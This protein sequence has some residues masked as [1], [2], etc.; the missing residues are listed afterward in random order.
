MESQLGWLEG[1]GQGGYGDL[2]TRLS[3]FSWR[4]GVCC[5]AAP[6]NV[7]RCVAALVEVVQCVTA[8]HVVVWCV[9]ARARARGLVC[10]VPGSVVVTRLCMWNIL[11]LVC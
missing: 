4:F 9:A 1:T 10:Y 11:G 7:V 8:P 2:V 5:G 3:E 6:V